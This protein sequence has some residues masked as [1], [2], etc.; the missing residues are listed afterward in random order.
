MQDKLAVSST[1]THESR[2]YTVMTSKIVKVTINTIP[3]QKLTTHTHT[4]LG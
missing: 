4:H 1:G 3:I 2:N